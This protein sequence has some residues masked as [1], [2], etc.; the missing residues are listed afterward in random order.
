MDTSTHISGMNAAS[1][2]R[3]F[4]LGGEREVN[5]IG[6][7]AMRLTGQPG[8]FGPYPD[9]E[10]GKALL[11]RA[12]ELG[13]TFLD[14]AHAYGPGW[15]E[16]LIAEALRPYPAG[17]VVATKAG[18][19]KTSP[20]AIIA[21]GR[22]GTL[23]AQA[24]ES[25][26]RLRLERLHLLQLHRPD[27]AVP[28]ADQVGALA[29]LREEGKVSLIGLSNVTREQVEDASAI[30]PI[31]SVQ[32]R[33]NPVERGD[34]ALVDL[35]AARGIAFVPHGPLG[36]HPMR[37]G[38]ALT[39]DVASAESQGTPAQ[40]ALAWLLARAPNVVVI[41]GTTSIEHLEENVDVWRVL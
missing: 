21:D 41:P 17:L 20:T 16:T 22:P 1:V 26:H 3:T 32:N 7:G 38:A 37:R 13:V 25:L 24:E 29:R 9:W 5:R 39:D 27:P 36:A 34:D 11:H 31:A 19:T 12:I 2:P 8:N 35:C 6:F 23:R 33:Y 28:L 40:R 14:T 4:R 10:A 15:N 18:V 30:T